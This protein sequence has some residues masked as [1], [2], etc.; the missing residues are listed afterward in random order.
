MGLTQDG[1]VACFANAAGH[2]EPG[3]NF[4]IE[5]GVPDLRRLPP[6]EDAR[7]FSHAP[8]YVGYD[9]YTDL[10]TQQAMSHH[11]VANATGIDE[12]RT[13]FRYVWPSELDLMAKLAGLSLVHRWPGWDRS[14]FTGQ[15]TSHVSVWQKPA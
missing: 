15:S 7:V 6:G 1:Q 2:L 11:F 8:G 5:V 12:T 13:P 14:P 3:G 9:R 10:A 4:L